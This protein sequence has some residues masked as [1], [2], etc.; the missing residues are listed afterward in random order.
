METFITIV[1]IL[2]LLSIVVWTT[3]FIVQA[4]KEHRK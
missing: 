2:G 4:V 1:T 3:S